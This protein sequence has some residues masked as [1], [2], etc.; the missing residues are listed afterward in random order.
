MLRRFFPAL[1]L[2]TVVACQASQTSCSG[3]ESLPNGRFE[4][5]AIRGA[6]AVRITGTGFQRLNTLAPTFLERLAPGSELLIPLPCSI[7]NT[8][9]FGT[10]AVGDEGALYCTA[11]S[12][13]Q[14][15]G[16]CDALD[17]PRIIT[18][19]VTNLTLSPKSPDLVEAR[20]DVKVATGKIHVSTVNRSSPLCGF[21]K[22]AKC[23]LD[24]DTARNPP[25][26]NPLTVQLKLVADPAWD[27]LLSIEV[28]GSVGT[29]LCGTSGAQAA[30]ACVDPQD[31]VVTTE[32]ACT[33]CEV[34]DWSPVK[35]VVV[36]TLIKSL[37]G[38]LQK[39]IR[40][41]NCRGCD[42][43]CP[44]NAGAVSS[45]DLDA[46]VCVD[47]MTLACVPALIGVEGRLSPGVLLPLLPAE[48][49]LDLH[50]GATGTA[51]ADDAGLTIPF[52]GGAK[53][54]ERASCVPLLSPP[55]FTTLPLPAFDRSA[56]QGYDLAF[57]FSQ[58]LL[59]RAL[60]HAQQSGAFCAELT[61]AQVSQLDSSL[62][63]GLLPSLGLLTQKQAVPLRAVLRPLTAPTATLG[64]GTIDPL[65]QKPLEPLVRLEWNDLEIDLYALIDER[66]V[67]L[68]T[69]SADLKLPLGLSISGCSTV[70]PVIGD[71]AGAVTDVKVKNSELLAEN[72]QGLASLV[73]TVVALAEPQL[74]QVLQGFTVPAFSDFQVRL[75]EAKGLGQISGSRNF[76]HAALYAELLP[77]LQPC[78]VA[79]PKIEKLVAGG[80]DG[81]DEGSFE[82]LAGVSSPQFSWR[83]RGGVWSM[84]KDV[85]VTGQVSVRH[86]I[87]R[88]PRAEVLEVRVRSA[89]SPAAVSQPATL[90][91]PAR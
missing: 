51:V 48:P 17:L 71:L 34:V 28:A 49:K 58:Q 23:G 69:V 39:T 35:S 77:A 45:C 26:D 19:T 16:R 76:Q 79:S 80:R 74:G 68:F 82:L 30:P 12:C 46:G 44:T 88:L 67:R 22:P 61:T 60:F 64:E 31:V 89:A 85:P 41:Q 47:E 37:Q 18:M 91:L 52:R 36:D 25:V 90:T 29:K 3:L 42:A 13:G 81:D 84:W 4:G 75:L 63:S 9:F 8:G 72:P 10:L 43:G 55:P 33:T 6:A 20:L 27:E 65:S 66:N 32:G 83:V 73:P 1:A 14:N 11:E 40:K 15:D 70:T 59:S 57:G 21:N 24:F 38:L 7:Q 53:E 62:L 86:P 5:E 54:V 56:G 78:M 87:F 50:L 2:C